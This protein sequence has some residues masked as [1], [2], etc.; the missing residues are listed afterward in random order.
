MSEC[1]NSKVVKTVSVFPMRQIST[2]YIFGR[3]GDNGR[4]KVI[5]QELPEL[6]KGEKYYLN[7][8]PVCEYEDKLFG[9]N[10]WTIE[11]D[12]NNSFIVSSCL[13]TIPI[14]WEGSIIRKPC[15]SCD[16]ET[17]GDVFNARI[18]PS[19]QPGI[20]VDT[21]ATRCY[22]DSKCFETLE[23]A[24]AYA[25]TIDNITYETN[26]D[27]LDNVIVQ[28]ITTSLTLT[29][30]KEPD[31]ASV[32]IHPLDGRL[33]VKKKDE[34]VGWFVNDSGK[35]AVIKKDLTV[36]EDKGKAQ[37][38]TINEE[39]KTEAVPN[40]TNGLKTTVPSQG[41][42]FDGNYVPNLLWVNERINSTNVVI[43]GE[44]LNID[45]PTSN[46]GGIL[47]SGFVFQ[48]K[49][50][51]IPIIHNSSTTNIATANG[52]IL[53]MPTNNDNVFG[54]YIGTDG[55]FYKLKKDATTEQ[56][57]NNEFL[58]LTNGA[59]NKKIN[60]SAGATSNATP[61]DA[62][63]LTNKE[64]VDDRATT[65]ETNA[66]T[67]TDEKIAEIPTGGGGSGGV[68]YLDKNTTSKD[69]VS[70]Y[71]N[72]VLQFNRSNITIEGNSQA[73]W[74]LGGYII[75]T[76]QTTNTWAYF[77]DLLDGRLKKLTSGAST[78]T[79]S[80]VDD[81]SQDWFRGVVLYDKNNKVEGVTGFKNPIE[82]SAPVTM[83]GATFNATGSVNYNTTPVFNKG[84]M[85]SEQV[86][87]GA[88][89]S[90]FQDRPSF[91]KGFTV[92]TLVGGGD[93]LVTTYARF[94]SFVE[95]DP[96]SDNEFVTKKYVD[97]KIAELQ[98]GS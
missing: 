20:D 77:V 46:V 35:I 81:A 62:E 79:A 60:F 45:T 75:T 71:K 19:I 74:P 9:L 44:T 90:I 96:T 25:E 58:A 83:N 1:S 40:F 32:T 50:T 94:F 87:V 7:L 78:L 48:C 53:A 18:L 56:L 93:Q 4:Y 80:Q 97:A 64:Y 63:D 89:N 14:L 36:E 38:L 52:Q 6:G 76:D 16:S 57:G 17:V 43:Y 55:K 92:G 98:G 85:T 8:S 70:Q 67:Y 27:N 11:L 21:I 51:T 13:T 22:V 95:G 2:A 66:K 86:G 30:G 84:V 23:E 10:D 26:I 3:T 33:Y 91:N 59:T 61:T 31:G 72:T 5:F 65:A 12:S 68:V 42:V 88:S 73:I 54:V 49:T 28:G 29:T 37:F 15:D 82:F 47:A 41:S 24:K 34:Y 69:E 39:G